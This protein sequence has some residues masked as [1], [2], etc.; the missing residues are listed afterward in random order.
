[1]QLG[2]RPLG[3][4]GLSVTNLAFGTGALG[5]M[6]EVFGYR[7]E[8]GVAL[9][10]L[11]EVFA[12]PVSL[13]DT[14]N[15][16]GDSERL[17]G[18]VLLEIGGL[19]AGKVI[20]TKVDPDRTGDFSGRRVRESLEE[21]CLR[22]HLDHLPLVFLHDPDRV[23]FSRSMAP[24]GAV[25]MLVALQQDGVIGHLGVAGGPVELMRRY[26]ATGCFEVLITH[27]RYTLLDRSAAP[28][29]RECAGAGMAVINAAPFGGGMLA[30]GPALNPRYG[31]RP[32]PAAVRQKAVEIEAVCRAYD[33]PL[34][35][36]AL[37]FSMRSQWI[38]S[39]IVGVTTP[40]QVRQAL[41]MVALSI[42]P[43]FWDE[44]RPLAAP[45]EHWLG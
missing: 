40:E 13:V 8:R 38:S 9:E 26:A 7:V 30:A 19:P 39:T 6:P 28:L 15:G 22:L 27:N 5:S 10:T 12:G 24:D 41:E 20:S 21:S 33:V 35:A 34:A 11:R 45:E 37:Q 25:P 43:E 16:Y 42:P 3:A 1:V 29:A 36:A 17:I 32:A 31:Y 2:A 4:T 23:T 18:E 14:S 44:V